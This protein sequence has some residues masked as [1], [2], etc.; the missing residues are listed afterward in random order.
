M[1]EHVQANN[2][3]LSQALLPQFFETLQR[4][5]AVARELGVR[6][7]FHIL[8]IITYVYITIIQF[9]CNNYVCVYV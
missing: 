6:V 9:L 8:F 7:S 1:F 3:E 4:T 2:S 5:A